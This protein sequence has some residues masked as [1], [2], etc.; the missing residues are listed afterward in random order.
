MSQEPL[1][2]LDAALQLPIAER[3]QL[4]ARLIESTVAASEVSVRHSLTYDDW[5]VARLQIRGQNGPSAE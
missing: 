4:A 5:S 3:G 1:N 2:L